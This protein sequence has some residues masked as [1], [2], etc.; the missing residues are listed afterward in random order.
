MAADTLASSA[1]RLTGTPC[2]PLLGCRAASNPI[3]SSGVSA[4]PI[5]VTTTAP[6]PTPAAVRTPRREMPG[7]TGAGR[8]PALLCDS[9]FSFHGISVSTSPSATLVCSP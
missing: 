6:I 5:E 8:S 3:G 4:C 7:V 2:G 1:V 9:G